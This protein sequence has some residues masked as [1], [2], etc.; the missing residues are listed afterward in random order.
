MLFDKTR[1]RRN[2]L[3]RYYATRC[4]N[5]VKNEFF[6][7]Q[8][9]YSLQT[10]SSEEERTGEEPGEDTGSDHGTREKP[11]LVDSPPPQS[12]SEAAAAAHNSSSEDAC[13]QTDAPPLSR[14]N[15]VGRPEVPDP[16]GSIATQEV[17]DSA[18]TRPDAFSESQLDAQPGGRA[19]SA[20]DNSPPLFTPQDRGPLDEPDDEPS[21]SRETVQAEQPAGSHCL[22]V[23]SCRTSEGVVNPG[24]KLMWEANRSL[25]YC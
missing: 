22:T 14:K 10:W 1:G 17:V 18:T 7:R 3:A 2:F 5:C 9:T 6:C 15:P 19:P 12:T 4:L 8:L 11:K 20:D 23:Y 24:W 21:V 13:A 25:K 16:S